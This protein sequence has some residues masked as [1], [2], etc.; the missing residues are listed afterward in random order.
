M[1]L[2]IFLYMWL[3]LSTP[4]DEPAP[5]Y[6]THILLL[7]VAVALGIQLPYIYKNGYANLFW[8]ALFSLGVLGLSGIA[9]LALL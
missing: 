2:C 9:Y 1:V 5:V 4:N 8:M 3:Q 7:P 6:T